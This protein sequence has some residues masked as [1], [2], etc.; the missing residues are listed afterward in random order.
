VFSLDSSCVIA[1]TKILFGEQSVLMSWYLFRMNRFRPLCLLLLLAMSLF[2]PE[3]VS[4]ADENASAPQPGA[5]PAAKPVAPA[6][7]NTTSEPTMTPDELY[8]LG[9]NLFDQYAPPEVKAQYDFPT[10]AQWDDFAAKL[11]SALEG[12]SIEELAAYEPQARAALTAL[13]TLP[14]YEDYA[15]W[16]EERLDLIET[17]RLAARPAPPAQHLPP[18]PIHGGPAL[19]GLAMP[20]YDLWCERLRGRPSPANAAAL[21]PTLQA[22]FAAAGVPREFAWMAEVESSLNAN[23]RS[24]AGAKGLFQLMP[25]TAKNL[26]MSTWFPDERTDPAR[27]ARGAAELLRNLHDRFGDWPLALAAYNA[28]EGRVSRTLAA[29]KARTFS[30]ISASLPVE[31]RLYVPK[32]F[33]TI[34]LRTGVQPD[35]LAAD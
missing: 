8:D 2:A 20:Y 32:I 29:K 1:K 25:D 23:A 14:G 5:A 3:R 4:G 9:K 27:S 7:S 6:A 22:G 31:T 10:K 15:G 35:R 18:P 34:A 16:L 26:G 12:D 28:G 30:E 17:A 24:P 11:Q 21:M 13:R 33:A 19:R